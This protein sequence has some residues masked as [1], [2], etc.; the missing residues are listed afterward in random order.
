M[1][2]KKNKSTKIAKKIDHKNKQKMK[3]ENVKPISRY[4]V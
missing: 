3:D 4:S 1:L 2:G